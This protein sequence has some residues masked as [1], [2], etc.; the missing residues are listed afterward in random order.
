[1]SPLE[2]DQLNVCKYIVRLDDQRYVGTECFEVAGKKRNIMLI[3]DSVYRIEGK[4]KWI[5]IDLGDYDPSFWNVLKKSLKRKYNF[6]Y[7]L[8]LPQKMK[9]DGNA[10]V[11][12]DKGRIA[13]YQHNF[14]NLKGQLSQNTYIK[15]TKD[16]MKEYKRFKP[17]KLKKVES[18]EL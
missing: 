9:N 3:Y 4:L 11:F 6:E 7:E 1:M 10:M 14:S 16:Q 12:F 13:L 2:V 8:S 15:Y 5:A 18:S 17:N